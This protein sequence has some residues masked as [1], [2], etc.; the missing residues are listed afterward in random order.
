MPEDAVAEV[1]AKPPCPDCKG[2]GK[3]TVMTQSGWTDL[4]TCGTCSG[5]GKQT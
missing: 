1:T 5:G 3:K 4:A 2:S